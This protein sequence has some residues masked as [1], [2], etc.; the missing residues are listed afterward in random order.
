MVTKAEYISMSDVTQEA[1]SL[2][3]FITDFD[4]VPTIIHHIFLLCDN[5]GAIAQEKDP[6]S[7]E[8]SKYI[9]RRF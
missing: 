4:V 9:L 7:Y 5:N 6:R 2:K 1:T 8:K 3:K